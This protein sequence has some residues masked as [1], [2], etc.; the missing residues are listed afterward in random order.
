KKRS[1]NSGST[2]DA[3]KLRPQLAEIDKQAADPNL[4]SNPQRSQQVMREKKRLEGLL[5][6]EAD[7]IRRSEDISAYFDLAKEGEN[8]EADIRREIDSLRAKVDQL[9]TET[10][11]CGDN[12]PRN[13]IV[14]IHPG[15][16]GTESQ[17]W[18]EM[19]MRMYLRWAER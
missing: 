16:G 12:D 2:F 5:S 17:D 19:L 1:A 18:A 8:V 4:W 3:G 6:N 7:L 13:A 10:L 9:E 11:L 14:T 15:A